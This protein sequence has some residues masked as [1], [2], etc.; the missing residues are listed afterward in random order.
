MTFGTAV[1][2]SGWGRSNIALKDKNIF[3]H[4]A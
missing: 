1:N 3:G 2:E 4:E